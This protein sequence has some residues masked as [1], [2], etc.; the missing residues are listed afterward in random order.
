MNQFNSKLCHSV[1]SKL[2]TNLQCCYRHKINEIFSD[3][4]IAISGSETEIRKSYHI[5]LNNYHI[6]NKLERL[7][8]QEVVNYL[9]YIKRP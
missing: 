2:N 1:K 9:K 4:D 8:F 6:N 3:A 7:K 5:V